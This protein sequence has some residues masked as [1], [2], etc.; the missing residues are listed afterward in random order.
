MLPISCIAFEARA[1]ATT[2]TSGLNVS[3]DNNKFFPTEQTVSKY[4]RRFRQQLKLDPEDAIAIQKYIDQDIAK[5]PGMWYL[6]TV[7]VFHSTFFVLS[8]SVNSFVMCTDA[9]W[10]YT[11]GDGVRGQKKMV[12][13][14]QTIEQQKMMQK[15]GGTIVGMDATYGTNL[16]GFPLLLITVIDNHNHGFSLYH[17]HHK[18]VRST[19]STTT[20]TSSPRPSKA[21]CCS[22]AA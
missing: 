5:H 19:S 14:H 16:W 2:I 6:H 8:S 1:F 7:V 18:L 10:S 9:K 15:Y 22:R 21:S 3:T 17:H 12:L 4:A 20:T 13:V 11:P